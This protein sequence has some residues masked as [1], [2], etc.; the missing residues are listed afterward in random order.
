M[1]E[2]RIYY[3][4]PHSPFNYVPWEGL[5][6][7]YSVALDI[8]QSVVTINSDILMQKQPQQYINKRGGVLYLS[9]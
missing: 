9:L 5:E 8:K 2:W 1:L 7:G 4:R 6:Q 3:V